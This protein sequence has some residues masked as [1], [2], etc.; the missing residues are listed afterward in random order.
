MDMR[1]LMVGAAKACINPTPDMYP[2][3]SSFADWGVAP[4]L[5]SE[6]YDDM[7]LPHHCH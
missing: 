7:Y 1:K 4:L 5:Q 2:I 6:I 3:P